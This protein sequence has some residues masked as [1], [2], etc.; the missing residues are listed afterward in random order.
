M[1][2]CVRD[3]TEVTMISV[4]WIALTL[5][6]L[7]DCCRLTTASHRH[8]SNNQTEI[9]LSSGV[10]LQQQQQPTLGPLNLEE[11]RHQ[12]KQWNSHPFIDRSASPSSLGRNRRGGDNRPPLAVTDQQND[13][14]LVQTLNGMVKGVSKSALGQ[15]V[16]VFLGVSS[17]L[18]MF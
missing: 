5:M 8:L 13:R 10:T 2:V 18:F 11:A 6:L 7:S 9:N 1:R 15:S 16:D 12:W 14:L 3:K 4:V 17:N